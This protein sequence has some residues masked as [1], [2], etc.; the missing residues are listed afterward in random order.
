[1]RLN[2]NSISGL[3]G[4]FIVASWGSCPAVPHGELRLWAQA[5]VGGG[6]VG[7]LRVLCC[8]PVSGVVVLFKG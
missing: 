5:S 3:L 8:V 6:I 1:M 7:R 2:H 4:L